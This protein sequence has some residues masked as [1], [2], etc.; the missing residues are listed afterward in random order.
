MTLTALLG[1]AV[2]LTAI[3]AAFTLGYIAGSR[4]RQGEN[5]RLRVNIDAAGFPAL[6]RA[7]RWRD[8]Y[9]QTRANARGWARRLPS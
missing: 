7:D 5:E 6:D 2:G 9:W 8:L 1:L 4:D 3:A